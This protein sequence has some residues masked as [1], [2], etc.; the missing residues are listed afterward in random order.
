MIVQLLEAGKPPV[1]APQALALEPA[2][3]VGTAQEPQAQLGELRL[4]WV[5]VLAVGRLWVR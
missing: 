2:L 1:Q 5:Q 3:L 4:R